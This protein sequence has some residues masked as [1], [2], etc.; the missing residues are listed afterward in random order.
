L[1]QALANEASLVVSVP[2]RTDSS[3]SGKKVGDGDDVITQCLRLEAELAEL[4]VAWDQYF[5]GMERRPP[6]K[7]HEAFKK[8]L[9]ALKSLSV[10]Q[11]AARFRAQ[12]LAQKALTYERLWERSLAELEAGTSRRDVRRVRNKKVQSSPS[13]PMADAEDLD[14]SDFDVDDDE[15]AVSPPVVSQPVAAKPVSLPPLQP[16]VRPPT[17]PPPPPAASNPSL[18]PVKGVPTVAPL[19]PKVAA[20]PAAAPAPRSADGLSDQKIRAI[21]DAYLTAKKRCGEDTSALS[22]NAVADSLRKQVPTLMKQHNAKSVDFK[23]V[24]KD[25]KAVLRA[26]PKED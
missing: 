24:I 17:V 9:T 18:Q 21:Y 5:S 1:V 8:A 4:H 13:R 14:V 16:T 10:R 19:V 25:G 15:P 7:R 23:V 11:V 12:S 6:T 22:L 26:L 2:G 3:I 20:K